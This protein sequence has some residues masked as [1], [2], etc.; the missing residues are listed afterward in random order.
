MTLECLTH[1]P[2]PQVLA[3]IQGGVRRE[4]EHQVRRAGDRLLRDPPPEHRPGRTPG[5]PEPRLPLQV[6]LRG[7]QQELPVAREPGRQ[8]QAGCCTQ[9][10]PLI[11]Q[12]ISAVARTTIQVTRTKIHNK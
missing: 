6:P 3:V 5:P 1:R 10:G 9:A 4:E 11:L 12:V 8:S 2:W 7:L